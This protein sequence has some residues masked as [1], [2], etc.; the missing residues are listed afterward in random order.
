MGSIPPP[1]PNAGPTPEDAARF[2]EAFHAGIPRGSAATVLYSGGL[3]S[4]VVAFCAKHLGRDV[5]LVSVGTPD[6]PDRRA[7]ETGARLLGLPWDYRALSPA[8]IRQTWIDHQAELRSTRD[9]VRPVRL[10]F[11][12]GLE[13]TDTSEVYCGQGADELFGGY[14]HFRG[15]TA[16][17]AELRRG[18]DL[19]ELEAIEWPWAQGQAR[20]LGHSVHAPFLEPSVRTLAIAL[21]P[22]QWW[23]PGVGSSR[24][25]LQACKLEYSI[26]SPK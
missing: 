13:E 12:L 10:A 11:R 18:S 2:F 16:A 26:V 20:E 8:R 25:D 14:A 21:S 3:D 17:E 23:T 24:V 15:L 19:H 9:S 22:A 4:S 5:R 6:A 1:P 7:A